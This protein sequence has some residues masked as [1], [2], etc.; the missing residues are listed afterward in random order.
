MIEDYT[1]LYKKPLTLG[2]IDNEQYDVFISVFTKEERVQEVF[3]NISAA[4]KYW[5]VLQWLC[6]TCPNFPPTSF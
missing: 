4:Q 6:M 2:V 5:L 1:Y 3:R